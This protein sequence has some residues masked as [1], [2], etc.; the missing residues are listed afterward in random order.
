MELRSSICTKSSW[1]ARRFT[2]GS[3]SGPSMV[4]VLPE[5][6]WPYAKMQ[7][8]YPSST[9]MTRGCTASKT[10]ACVDS[11][12]K[13][14]SNSNELTVRRPP[15]SAAL[16]TRRLDVALALPAVGTAI[17]NFSSPGNSTTDWSAP[18]SVSCCTTGRT[19][20]KTRMLPC[21]STSR[22]WSDLRLWDSWWYSVLNDS[23]SCSACSIFMAATAF[24]SATAAVRTSSISFR[25]A[26][27][28]SS[29][30]DWKFIASVSICSISSLSFLTCS[31]FI[32]L[33]VA[34]WF[35]AILSIASAFSLSIFASIFWMAAFLAASA[36]SSTCLIC[37]ILSSS[38]RERASSTAFIRSASE[39]AMTDLTASSFSTCIFSTDAAWADSTAAA[40]SASALACVAC[41]FAS[42]SARTVSMDSALAFAFASFS[43]TSKSA[44]CFWS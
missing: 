33:T 35:P 20:Q 3:W 22:L 14:L 8:L 6:V 5:P 7:T 4:W 39:A 32:L 34:S 27:I 19:R 26:T 15:P 2:P 17:R 24:A 42:S 1:M 31:S 13:V 11:G 16:P 37:A 41:S 29:S 38:A 43:S 25:V 28:A 23:Q 30:S 36:C 18:A 44:R 12:A 40:R 10:C 9:E 21:S